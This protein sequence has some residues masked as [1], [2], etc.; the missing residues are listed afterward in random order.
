MARVSSRRR[1]AMPSLASSLLLLAAAEMMGGRRV[2]LPARAFVAPPP[3]AVVVVVVAPRRPTA[4]SSDSPYRPPPPMTMGA[5]ASPDPHHGDFRMDD[6]DDTDHPCDG[7]GRTI[8]ADRRRRQRLDS[9][10]LGGFARS[11]A[12]AASIAALVATASLST[13]PSFAADAVPSSSSS[14]SSSS[15]A[16]TKPGGAPAAYDETWNL[17][18]KYALDRSYN[19]QNWDDAYSTY[20]G[21]L[22]TTTT[23]AANGADDD[24]GRVMKAVTDLVSSMGDKYTRVLDRDAY[25]KIQKFDL[26][27]VGATLMPDPVTQEIIVGAPPVS[28]SAADMA[29][30]RAGDVIVA[31]NGMNTMGRTA[32]DIIDQITEDPKQGSITFTVRSGA[33][34]TA[35]TRDVV[36]KREFAEVR[37]P[38][39][40]RV[41]ETRSDGTKVGYVRI[42][43]FNSLVKPKLE[44]ALRDLESQDVN[45]YVVDVRGNPGGAFQSAIEIAGLFMSDRLATDVVDG[46]GVDLKFRTSKDRVVIGEGDPLAIWVDG[47]SA[48]ASEVLAGAL[49]DNCRAVVMGSTSFGKG[50]VQA[51]YGLKNGYGLVL[52]VAKYLTPGG[53]D[54]NKVGI[55]PDV[56]GEVAL[57]AVPGFVPKFGSD[58]SRVDFEDV[59][60][61]MA[62]CSVD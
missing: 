22:S 8:A 37:D 42:A 34:A 19:G 30:L 40:Y 18:R 43:E 14:S 10:L 31:V 50:L 57:P 3:R 47:G 16:T 27:G 35:A 46:N 1:R 39:S 2:I 29:G 55:A 21:G 58:T 61:R 6:D 24:E 12:L 15:S 33:T 32:F 48:S 11:A 53:T 4:S 60:R 28:K 25:A 44:S 51:V 54:I 23:T 59:T 17:V 38:I 20:S 41:S 62:M 49:R 5:S 56:L 36:M 13:S 9:I 26:I 52:T 45:A 7:D